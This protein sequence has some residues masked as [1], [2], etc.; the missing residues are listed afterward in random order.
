MVS[1]PITAGQQ[2]DSASVTLQ[3]LEVSSAKAPKEVVSVAPTHTIAN[4]DLD[5]MGITGISDAIHRMPGVIL[6]DYGGTGGLKTVSIRGLGPQHTGVSYDGAQLGDTQSGQIDLSRYSLDNVSDISMVIGDNED[7]FVPARTAA[8]SSSIMISSW[9]PVMGDRKF[10]L[11]AKLTAGAFGYVSPYIRIGSGIGDNMAWLFTGDYIHSNNNYTFSI[12]NGSETVKERRNNSEI[13]NGHIEANF[14]WKPNSVS[15]LNV[16]YYYFDSFRH[17]P[18]PAILYNN[19]SH[20]ALK[21]VNMFGQAQYRTRLSR[22]FSLN[23]LG[24]FNWSKNRYT[25]RDG[26]YPGGVLDNRYIQ[27]EAYGTATLLCV[28]VS[29]LSLSYAFDYFY[30]DLHS[31]LKQHNRPHRNSILQGLNAKYHYRWFTATA[32]ALLS[33]YQDF[34]GDGEKKLSHTRLTPSAGVSFQPWMNQNFFIRLN[35]KGIFRM[36]TFNELYFDHFG[37]I[38]LNPEITDQLNAGLTYNLKSQSWISNLN[39]TVDGYFN[40][41][42]NK[43]VAVPYNMFVWTMTNLG[44]VEAYGIDLSLNAEFPVYARQSIIF[45]GNYSWQKALS[46]TSRDKL[47]WNKQLPYTPVHSGAFSVAWEN[48]WVSLVAH[49]YGCSARYSSTNNLPSTRLHGYMEF[50]FAAYHTFRFHGHELQL[51]A[52]LINAFDARYEIVARYPMP[53]RSWSASIRFTL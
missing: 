2:P 38:N 51:R 11:T 50:G 7:I 6:R 49:S 52:D 28:P 30:N 36:P 17:L 23:V 37:S 45:N 9:N 29:G 31:N 3:T 12:P 26:K 8:A 27:R 41:V 20:E 42:R 39:V 35:Y 1:G 44:R 10:N 46:K 15:T 22:I 4:R 47:D 24:K 18:G 14:R 48:P 19:E 43:I 34:P 40:R 25:D 53:G 33:I 32:R 21:D 16:K 13:D 5:K